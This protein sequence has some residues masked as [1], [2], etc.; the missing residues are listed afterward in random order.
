MK[1]G[2]FYSAAFVAFS[3]ISVSL[4]GRSEGKVMTPSQISNLEALSEYEGG[5]DVIPCYS[6]AKQ[7]YGRSYVDCAGCTRII[8]WEGTGTEA[9]CTTR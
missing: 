6:S 5:G 4:A 3:A 2:I 1:K 7:R 9:R 8:D